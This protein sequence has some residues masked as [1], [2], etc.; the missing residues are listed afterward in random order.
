M[1][2]GLRHC[3]LIG[4]VL[5]SLFKKVVIR[6]LC[7]TGKRSKCKEKKVLSVKNV[8]NVKIRKF[9]IKFKKFRY[10]TLIRQR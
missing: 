3:T 8:E 5:L 4:Y 1:G 10:W 2:V 9:K 6:I 7:V